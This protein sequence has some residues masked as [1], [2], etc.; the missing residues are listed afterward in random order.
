MALEILEMRVNGRPD[1]DVD[2]VTRAARNTTLVLLCYK[3]PMLNHLT[4]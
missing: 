2:D 1:V 4:G 3:I